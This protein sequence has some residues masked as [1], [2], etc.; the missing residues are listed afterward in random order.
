MVHR[1]L[2]DAPWGRAMRSQRCQG[3]AVMVQQEACPLPAWEDHEG[4]RVGKPKFPL[5]ALHLTRVVSGECP[6]H[7]CGGASS[8]NTRQPWGRAAQV[9]PH[10]T[11]DGESLDATTK[12]AATHRRKQFFT[13]SPALAVCGP[14][15]SQAD[16]VSR[17]ASGSFSFLWI[18]PLTFST[19]TI[20]KR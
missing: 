12:T 20:M 2:G 7:L 3:R 1:V 19:R 4:A 15:A 13:I 10:P 16:D 11:Q 9:K 18:C 14:S 5:C 17:R 8:L 6:T